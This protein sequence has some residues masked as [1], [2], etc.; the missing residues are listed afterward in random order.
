MLNLNLNLFVPSEASFYGHSWAMSNLIN[1]CD[2]NHRATSQSLITVES[3]PT[4]QEHDGAVNSLTGRENREVSGT[5]LYCSEQ[6]E[7]IACRDHM[8]IS[9]WH[10]GIIYDYKSAV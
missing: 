3:H 8:V 1:L 9:T 10:K 2:G 4:C 7:H 6:H 5:Q